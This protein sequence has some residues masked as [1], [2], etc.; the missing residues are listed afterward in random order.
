MVA[1]DERVLSVWAWPAFS[2]QV[3]WKL[4]DQARRQLG[5]HI[6]R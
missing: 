6:A 2:S 1:G 5:R 3:V 4:Q